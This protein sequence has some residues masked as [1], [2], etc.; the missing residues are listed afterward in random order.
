MF[1]KESSM[2]KED[3]TE[4]LV[5]NFETLKTQTLKVDGA[6]GK[7][8]T[9]FL[10]ENAERVMLAPAST[11]LDYVCAYQGGLVE[12]S[13]RV[14]S[15]MAKARNAYGLGEALPVSSV[16]LVSLFHDIGKIG[17]KTKDYYLDNDSQ[18]HRD[19]LG[20]MF[21]VAERFQHIPVSQLSLMH[22]TENGVQL[23][24]DEW[25]AISSIRER[26]TK[27]EDTPV[28]GEPLLAVILQQAVKI[29]CIFGK[30]KTEP[31]VVG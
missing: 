30:G 9:G 8:L 23:D 22:L 7:I 31:T 21:N 25:Y 27:N 19:K 29:S 6:R 2:A 14:L 20:V 3:R 12:H 5:K 10:D 28:N 11:R 16:V 24:M 4:T 13:L 1:N 18:W 17:S 26:S 15:F